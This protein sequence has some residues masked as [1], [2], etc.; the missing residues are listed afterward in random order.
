MQNR[1]KS[2]VKYLLSLSMLLPAASASAAALESTASTDE[3]KPVAQ[4]EA[5]LVAVAEKLSE[6]ARA[7]QELA[8]KDWLE[9]WESPVEG[10]G[11]LDD[12]AHLS[13]ADL[14]KSIKAEQA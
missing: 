14:L 4:A 13:S 2:F 3:A 9:W 7:E 6:L 8:W 11:E 10:P 1:D 12:A 5:P